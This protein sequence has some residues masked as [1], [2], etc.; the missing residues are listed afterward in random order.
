MLNPEK[1]IK[2]YNKIITFLETLDVDGTDSICTAAQ[3][4]AES[5]EEGWHKI[6]ELKRKYVRK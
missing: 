1:T 4:L 5:N 3:Q 6:E 2:V